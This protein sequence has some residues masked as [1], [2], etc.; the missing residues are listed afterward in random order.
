MPQR[1][2]GSE[3]LAREAQI[4]KITRLARD[5]GKQPPD[6]LSRRFHVLGDLLQILVVAK[7]QTAIAFEIGL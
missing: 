4:R 6:L 1:R 5:F 7:Q 3:L 2:A